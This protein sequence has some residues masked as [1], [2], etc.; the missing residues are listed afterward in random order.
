[1]WSYTGHLISFCVIPSKV[2]VSSLPLELISQ[3][4]KKQKVPKVYHDS[5]LT[6]TLLRNLLYPLPSTFL[7]GLN[8]I[9]K[10]VR[11]F[12]LGLCIILFCPIISQATAHIA[13]VPHVIIRIWHNLAYIIEHKILLWH[14]KDFWNIIFQS[15]PPF[16]LILQPTH[17]QL[18][19]IF[20][21]EWLLCYTF[22]AI[23]E[24]SL[25]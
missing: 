19:P 9:A 12:I 17:S 23:S 10:T 20:P 18:R 16:F 7:Q 24:L 22:L 13:I 4:Q 5:R 15:P 8:S 11:A 14:F 25:C 21:S 2:L 1:M 6:F 3:E